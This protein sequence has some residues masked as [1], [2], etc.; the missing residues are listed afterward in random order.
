MPRFKSEEIFCKHYDS[1]TEYGA[2]LCDCMN[3][4][5]TEEEHELCM[6]TDG[7]RL[8]C[9]HYEPCEVFHCEK[10]D[11]DYFGWEYCGYCFEED[12][13]KEKEFSV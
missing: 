5:V 1:W 10:H 3:S 6:P 8:E 4:A 9:A 11:H 7:R 13:Q 2:T 12:L